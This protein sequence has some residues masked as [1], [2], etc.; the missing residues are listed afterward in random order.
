M[1]VKE[2]NY[3]HTSLDG[4]GFRY[5]IPGSRR[6]LHSI[7]NHGDTTAEKSQQGVPVEVPEMTLEKRVEITDKYI[8]KVNSVL[9]DWSGL[10]HEER[11]RAIVKLQ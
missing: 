8:F 10:T 7:G 1:I 3:E 4:L 11:G 6:N 9:P 2:F 5:H